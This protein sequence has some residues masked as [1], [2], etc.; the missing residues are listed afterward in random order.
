[1][2]IIVRHVILEALCHSEE[3]S[4]RRIYF[5][6]VISSYRRHAVP[7]QSVS[8]VEKSLPQATA[9]ERLRV[10][11]KKRLKSQDFSTELEMTRWGVSENDTGQ[12]TYNALHLTVF[13]KFLDFFV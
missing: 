2:N 1:M 7:Y 6:F 10:F 8:G 5:P 13:T 9:G 12:T 4:D 3:A 11:R